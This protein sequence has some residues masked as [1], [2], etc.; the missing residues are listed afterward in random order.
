M[1]AGETTIAGS[2]SLKARGRL[3]RRRLLEQ[4][5]QHL[6]QA[7]LARAP[8]D[9]RRDLAARVDD[10]RVRR[11]LRPEAIGDLKARVEARRIHR[12]VRAQEAPRVGLGVVD[13][14]ADDC[15]PE[16]AIPDPDA[17]EV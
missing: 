1:R 17:L 3:A 13:L 11:P 9:L 6:G 8:G 5:V 16:R 15:E 7:R 4:G 10:H 12:G 14:Y 2:C